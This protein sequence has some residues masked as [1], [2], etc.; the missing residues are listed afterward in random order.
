[1]ARSYLSAAYSEEWCVRLLL[2]LTNEYGI[3]IFDPRVKAWDRD[4]VKEACRSQR[5][6]QDWDQ[7]GATAAHYAAAGDQVNILRLLAE[8]EGMDMDAIT[9][10]KGYTPALLAACEGREEAL[11]FLAEC[12][13][14]DLHAPS[15]P[16]VG[17]EMFTPLFLAATYGLVNIVKFLLSREDTL[18]PD[19]LNFQNEKGLTPLMAALECGEVAVAR[20]LVDKGAALGVKNHMQQTPLYFAVVEVVAPKGQEDTIKPVSM[21]ERL[22]V[23]RE[24]LAR[25]ADPTA[26]SKREDG[27]QGTE[28][29]LDVVK[30]CFPGS[31]LVRVIEE[32]VR[33][34]PKRRA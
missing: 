12:K 27:G 13:G 20:R 34:W 8:I 17:T 14:V 30:E 28:S 19:V 22:G 26:R 29:I 2:D 9:D 16:S 6:G 31:E 10:E 25:G 15:S 4:L 24:L 11:R 21:A 23:V 32:A 18:A 33:E 3:R 7:R 1:L 5:S